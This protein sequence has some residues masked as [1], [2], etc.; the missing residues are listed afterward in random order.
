MRLIGLVLALGL[1]LA[2]FVAEAQ[3]AARI[4]RVGV[5]GNSPSPHMDD[6]FRKGLRDLGW[7]EGQD[8]TLEYRYSEGRPERLP[9][10]AADLV[11]LNVD[12][13]VAWAPPRPE[14]RSEQPERSPSSFWFT[15]IPS[16]AARWQASHIPA[17]T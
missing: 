17:E 16:A 4:W 10:L 8:I 7:I 14:R 5:L 1:T 15:V 2:L 11:R 9:G 12:L 13:I 3:Q 6:A